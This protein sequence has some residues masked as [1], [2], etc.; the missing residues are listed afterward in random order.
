MLKFLK[1]IRKDK[2]SKGKTA[3]YLTYAIGEVVLVVIGILLAVQ[4][5]NWNEDRK[6]K[7][8]LTNIFKTIQSDL[9]RDTTVANSV[10]RLYDTIESNSN[11]VIRKEINASNYKNFPMLRSL[12][13]VYS[14]FSVQTKG[15]EML[16]SYSNKNEVQNDSL[17]ATIN[18]FYVPFL[19]IITDNNQ[20]IK[21]EVLDNIDAFKK[22]S[23][24]VDWTQGR[25][26][27][28]MVAY[29]VESEDYRK[30]VAANLIFAIQN[31][32]KVIV[33]YKSKATE[34]LEILRKK[35]PEN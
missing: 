22:E 8:E 10:I 25:F 7:R 21:K 26:T 34:L 24:F 28:E 6:V 4:I 11:K 5:N 33:V 30:R 9:Q 18:Q 17:I 23:W 29:F 3:D 15:F 2:L 1:S 32:K 27:D 20:I 16:K 14:P 31:H 13:T 19:Q 12:A 35:T